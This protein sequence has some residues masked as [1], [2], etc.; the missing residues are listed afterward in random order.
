MEIFFG[1]DKKKVLQALRYHFITRPEI[2]ILMILVNV[3]AIFSAGL[4]Y[5]KKVSPIA[6]LISSAL[7]VGLMIAFWYFLPSAVYRKASTF[8]DTFR[9][10]FSADFV[11]LENGKSSTDWEWNRFTSY[12]ESP[13]FFHLYFNAR[14]FFLVPKEAVEKDDQIDELRRFLHEHIPKRK[15]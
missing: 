11:R 9:M 15:K 3:F 7:W 1:Y 14:S 8:N 5:F 12:Y 13:H 10:V 4:F 6:F 2:R